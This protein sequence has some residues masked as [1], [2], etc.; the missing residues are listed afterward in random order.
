[1]IQSFVRQLPVWIE[2]TSGKQ[3]QAL[4]VGRIIPS[5]RGVSIY[6]EDERY[7]AFEMPLWW[8][9]T[10][11]LEVGDYVVW[12]P[13]EPVFS[14]KPVMFTDYFRP[15]DGEVIMQR[16]ATVTCGGKLIGRGTLT[17]SK[18]SDS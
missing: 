13:G 10:V 4:K 15:D 8:S 14:W 7:A 6:P 12:E 5:P 1:M 17:I 2:K 9:D 18:K 16:E 11:Q 3:V